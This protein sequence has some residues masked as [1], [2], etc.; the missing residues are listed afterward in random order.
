MQQSLREFETS[1]ADD[2]NTPRAAAA[3]FDLVKQAEKGLKEGMT[4]GVAQAY[5]QGLQQMDKVR[6]GGCIKGMRD[7]RR[8]T[9]FCE[10]HEQGE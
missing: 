2:L 3:L 1:L 4:P 8:H 10:E 6:T 7:G 5:L 9:S